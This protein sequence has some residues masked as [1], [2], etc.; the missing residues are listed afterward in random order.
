LDLFQGW[1][2]SFVQYLARESSFPNLIAVK[3][4]MQKLILTSL[5][6][7]LFSGLAIGVQSSLISVAGKNTGAMLT[8]LLVNALAGV[9]AGLLLLAVYIWQGNTAFSAI[10]APTLRAIVIAGLL[11]IGIIAGIAYTLPKIGV[12]AG[13]SMI[14]TGQMAMGVLVD[15]YGLADGEPIPLNMA[16]IGGLVLL[17]MGTWFIVPKN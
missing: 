13:L 5:I 2:K 3:D 4:I 1:L 12:A 8:G 11:G 16:R 14:I 15:T 7:A 17:A 6:V 10:Q 9:A